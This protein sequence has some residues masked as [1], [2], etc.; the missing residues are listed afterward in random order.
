MINGVKSLQPV[1]RIETPVQTA[2]A[3]S[4]KRERDKDLGHS[5]LPASRHRDDEDFHY[6][7]IH[8]NLKD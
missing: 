3:Q 6:E 1:H 8:F 7:S 4:P 2:P 5:T